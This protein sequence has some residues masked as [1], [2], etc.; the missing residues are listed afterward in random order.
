M[1]RKITTEQFRRTIKDAVLPRSTEYTNSYALSIRW[2]RDDRLAHQDVSHFRSLLSTL[3]LAEPREVVIAADDFT[4]GLTAQT[5]L[6]QMLVVAKRTNGRAI[7]VVHYAG[8]GAQDA[9]SL[10]LVERTGG[11]SF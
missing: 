5:G 3:R 9:D 11:H 6:E 2:E 4:P 1:D 8:H 10:L 7:V